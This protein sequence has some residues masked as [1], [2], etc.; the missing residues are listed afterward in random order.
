MSSIK[1]IGKFTA[2]LIA[3]STTLA[4]AA[5][6]APPR[7]ARAGPQPGG[8]ADQEDGPPQR[9]RPARSSTG[10]G[11]EREGAAAE[12]D[13]PAQGVVPLHV[14]APIVRR[15]AT[16][17]VV[18][19]VEARPQRPGGDADPRGRAIEQGL[20]GPGGRG[21]RGE[22]WP[23]TSSPRATRS[24][25]WTSAA[26]GGTRAGAQRRGPRGDGRGPS[27]RLSVPPRPPQPRRPQHRQ[28]RRA[29]RRRRGQPDRRMG[30]PA[31]RRR[32]H[33]GPP[34]RPQRPDPGLA[35]ARRRRLRARPGARPPGPPR[36]SLH[37]VRRQGQRIQ[38]RRRGQPPGGR[39]APGSTKSNSSPRR[40]TATSCSASNPMSPPLST[41]SWRPTSNSDRPSGNPGT[42]K[43]PSPTPTSKPHATNHPP[44][45]PTRSG[46]TTRPR[47]KTRPRTRNPRTPSNQPP[48]RA[49]SRPG[50]ARR[51]R[52]ANNV[53][54][55]WDS[56][57][58][59]ST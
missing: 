3:A 8:R 10:R 15:H 33:R 11:G 38:G 25:P 21:S 31:G 27:S 40:F 1:R 43:S 52:T 48:R 53:L 46:P 41:D 34:Q 7:A 47:P 22:G 17:G 57:R 51:T 19:P 54:L 4:V 30:L 28:A 35:H 49:T 14:Q 32:L 20:R 16:G 9:R 37:P 44:N 39:T 56:S 59:G 58:S 42:T 45:P 13:R 6:N 50:P 2:L 12:R 23:S 55:A 18:L 26:R 5:Q 24:S 29:R 36:P